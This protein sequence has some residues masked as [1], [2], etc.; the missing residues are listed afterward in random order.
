[1]SG[2]EA[3][4]SGTPKLNA[5]QQV[6]VRE[7]LIDLNA[8]PTAIRAGYSARTVGSK[9]LTKPDVPAAI[10]EAQQAPIKRKGIEQDPVLRR[11]WAIATADA[12][13]LIQ[14]TAGGS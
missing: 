10:A 1:M 5:R 12:N 8:M 4:D 2:P 11:L 7:Y 6:F 3:P 9:N 13:D 14:Y